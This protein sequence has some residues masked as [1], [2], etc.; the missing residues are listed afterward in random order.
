MK[1]MTFMQAC[2]DYFGRTLGQT[3]LQFRNELKGL[4]DT[5]RAEIKA[6]LEG[7]GLYQITSEIGNVVQV[8]A[9]VRDD[10]PVHPQMGDEVAA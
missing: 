1:T 4:N 3:L 5:D 6:G 10:D 8:A 2:G 9:P 7:T